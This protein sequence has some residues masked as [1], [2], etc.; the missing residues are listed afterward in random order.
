[1]RAFA[2]SVLTGTL[3][4]QTRAA[5]PAAESAG[6]LMAVGASLLLLLQAR[7]PPW[8][9]Q[10]PMR[11]QRKPWA[12]FEWFARLPAPT[13]VSPANSP[14]PSAL[15]SPSALSS[16]SALPSAL[17]AAA[18]AS[19]TFLRIHARS[20]RLAVLV[21]AGAALGA[22]WSAWLAHQRLAQALPAAL[23][24]RDL[25][26]TGV[27]SG[28][29]DAVPGGLRF[30]FDVEQARHDGSPVQVP[31]RIALG[32]YG[33]GDEQPSMRP[34][35]R[36]QLSVR[37]KQPHGL[38]N[39]HGFDV[40]AWW[41]TEGLRATGYV[42]PNPAR[43]IDAFVFSPRDA[44]HRAR[45]WLRDRIADALS[46]QRYASVIVALVIG[47]QRGVA[48]SDWELFNRSGI[49]HLVSISG[50]HI[51]MIAALAAG[52]AHGLWRHSL[53]AGGLLPVRVPAQKVA[54]GAGLL[55]ALAYVALAGFG[56]PAQRTL[57]M[58]AVAAAALWSARIVPASQVLVCA[59]TAVLLLD[60]W[61]VL[62]PGFWLSF[63]AIACIL[64]ASA[65][66]IV[67]HPDGNA[68][69]LRW[70]TA[71]AKATHTQLAVTI[72][73]LPLTMLM[74][75]QVSLVSPF[76]NALAIPVVSFLVTPLA[77]LG[78]VMPA[79]LCGWLLLAAHA[80]LEWLALLLGWLVALPLAVWQAPQ[81]G[82]LVTA[83]AL[84]G[85]LWMLMP[86]GWPW[87]WAGLLAWLPALAATPAAPS[88]GLW[89]TAFDVGQ[90][91]AVLVE[92]PHFRLLYDTGPAYSAESD[93]GSRVILPYLRARGIDRLDALVIS[94]SDSDHAG[95]ARSLLQAIDVGW[96]ASSLPPA[97]PLVSARHVGC[98]AGQRWQRDG[99]R[100]EFLHP[101][102]GDDPNTRPNTRSCTLKISVGAQS[103]LLAGDIEAAQE[104]ALLARAAERLKADVLLA[105]HHG[106]GTSSTPAFLDAVAPQIA[107]FQL[108]YR[109]RYRHPKAEVVERYTARGIRVLR[110]DSTGAVTLRMDG[111]AIAIEPV[112]ATP[113]YWSSRRCGQAQRSFAND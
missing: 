45:A 79:P 57:L 74:F 97:H 103:V 109:N 54:A 29:P 89:L 47:D 106:S 16:P 2:L 108:G 42:R 62:W 6:M 107:L 31:R 40:E 93:G 48:A 64:F 37:L 91:N 102:A 67:E 76:A 8:P 5:L 111:R 21:I 80:A 56:I 38:A 43:R 4:L 36:W 1:M 25:A 7:R 39:P 15:P 101:L 59:L 92:T 58:L 71:L 22:G 94:H 77:L 61:A 12:M 20:W 51:T 3:W 83:I 35:E 55:A 99:V 44:I 87:R 49:G 24:G 81:P 90:G 34:G 18:P 105:P 75:G 68:S 53:F 112:C 17:A 52:L 19:R 9:L 60:P 78:S 33:A 46:G 11:R 70:R 26:L 100:F 113:R 14:L 86:R 13:P 23:E 63:C 65:G 66:R 84:A 73:L 98:V 88:T 82:W 32:W 27:V 85:T 41:L 110:S 95:G 50:L 96:V 104:R 69:V 28:L 10:D 72:G 30:R